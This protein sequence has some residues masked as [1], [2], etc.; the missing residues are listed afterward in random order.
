MNFLECL[1][2]GKNESRISPSTRLFVR[3]T[4]SLLL[5]SALLCFVIGG[6]FFSQYKKS[7]SFAELD[8]G[9]LLLR[10]FSLAARTIL[11]E[12]DNSGLNILTAEYSTDEAVLY[13]AVVDHSQNILAHSDSSQVGSKYPLTSRIA[14][15]LH[16]PQF[17][18]FEGIFSGKPVYELARPLR[19][20]D[21]ILGTAYLGL[22]QQYIEDVV[23]AESMAFLKSL[24]LPFLILLM[25]A[26]VLSFLL[27]AWIK[28]PFY[29]LL[30]AV[31]GICR[32]NFNVR[33]DLP[34]NNE[35]SDQDSEVNHLSNNLRLKEQM[36]TD[37]AEYLDCTA[38]DKMLGTPRENGSYASRRQVTVLYAGIAGFG[39]YASHSKAEEVVAAL[40]EYIGIAT[41]TIFAHGGYVDKFMGDAVVGIFGVSVYHEDHTRRAVRAAWEFQTL[42]REHEGNSTRVLGKVRI[43]MSSGVVLSGNIGPVSRIEYSSI[44]ETIK[45]AFWLNSLAAEKEIII[46]KN[47]YQ[48]IKDVAFVEPLTPQKL[49][50]HEGVIESYRLQNFVE[51]LSGKVPVAK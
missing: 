5:I 45:E 33:L 21:K 29:K 12:G 7:V 46:S 13:L 14:E 38:L 11:W 18:T 19:F 32:G 8:K 36:K 9:W 47:I 20:Q 26:L 40:N 1:F 39:E 48:I 51:P 2:P 27:A 43:G 10:H 49:I 25:P 35:L 6:V 24:F 30:P 16:S 41:S 37:V 34:G 50:G 3:I 22:S 15:K 44:G 31:Q 42:L 28:F 17:T 4:F 23:D